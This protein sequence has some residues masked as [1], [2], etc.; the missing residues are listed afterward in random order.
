MLVDVLCGLWRYRLPS[1]SSSGIPLRWRLLSRAR[2]RATAGCASSDALGQAAE[3]RLLPPAASCATAGWSRRGAARFDGR[4]TYY[5]VDLDR[6]A[7][8]LGDAGAALHPGLRW[9][10]AA[11]GDAAAPTWPHA[12][13]VLFLCTGNSARSQMAEA[14]LRTAVAAA[15]S[16]PRSAGSHPKPLHPNAVRVMRERGIDIA[17]PAARSTSTHS[18]ASSSTA[19]SRCA[20]GC[21]R[22]ARSSRPPARRPLEH[23]RPGRRRRHRR[24]DL[25]GVRAHRRR[26]R[27]PHRLPAAASTHRTR[28]NR[29]YCH[30]RDRRDR[31]RPLHGRR[32]RTPRSTSTPTPLR[33]HAS[34]RRRAGLR[35]RRARQ[36]AAAAL[37]PEELGG[38]AD[39]RRRKP[40]PG[41]WN[42]IHFIVDDL[43]AEVARLAPRACVPQRRRQ[44]ARRRADPGRGSVRQP[45][46]LFPTALTSRSQTTSPARA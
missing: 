3:P 41:G 24:R 46:E 6:C 8:L 10:A 31:Q 20:T 26:A 11:T 9:H 1:S 2:A 40:G 39:A 30:D 29:R 4:D 32:R 34:A 42:R 22:S 38:P 27:R 5:R 45:V 36:P 17:R 44:R 35:R 21:A 33:V 15:P 25:S 13:R 12:S 18:P 14:L 19:S 7:A 23:R 16:R 28:P 37:G 43:D